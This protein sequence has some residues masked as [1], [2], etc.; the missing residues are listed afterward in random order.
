MSNK[1]EQENKEEPEQ[2][3]DS[4]QENPN[5]NIIL[6][7]GDIIQLDAPSNPDLNEK[8]FFIKFI[9]EKKIVLVNPEIFDV[10][11]ER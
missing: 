7:L 3:N 2:I 9:N 11:H 4:N 6:Q 10:N 1:E 8:I 5:L